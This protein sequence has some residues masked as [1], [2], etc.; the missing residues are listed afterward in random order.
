[1]SRTIK[2]QG[3]YSWFTAVIIGKLLPFM[4]SSETFAVSVC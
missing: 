3:L 2:A 4:V 1:M